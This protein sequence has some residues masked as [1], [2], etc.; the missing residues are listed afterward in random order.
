M[1]SLLGSILETPAW[2]WCF[3]ITG[4][5]LFVAAT[6]I[7][8]GTKHPSDSRRESVYALLF[9]LGI[10]ALGF[11]HIRLNGATEAAA[12]RARAQDARKQLSDLVKRLGPG[13][14]IDLDQF[15]VTKRAA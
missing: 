9:A 7:I 14:T 8:L 3:I 5:V 6:V 2:A 1:T 4:S 10:I 13:G 15:E 11:V 12:E